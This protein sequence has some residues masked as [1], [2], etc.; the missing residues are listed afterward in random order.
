[1]VTNTA[2]SYTSLS[3]PR[4][5]PLLRMAQYISCF[6]WWSPEAPN[7]SQRRCGFVSLRRNMK[8]L[9]K[10]AMLFATAA[11]ATAAGAQSIDNWRNSSSELVWKNGTNELCWR[12]SFWTPPPLPL[13][14][15]GLLLRLVPL[16][17]HRHRH[18]HLHLHQ[19]PCRPRLLHR[20]QLLLQHRHRHLLRHQRQLL[21]SL[22]QPPRSHTPPMPSLISTNPYSSPKAKPNWMIW[23]ARSRASTWKS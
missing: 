17:Q 13:V 2:P 7:T 22:L 6:G 3:C 21:P 12:N 11:L 1:M 18:R 15:M 19:L 10:V 4:L 9:N 23:S 16:R 8:K 5:K 14:A 20:P